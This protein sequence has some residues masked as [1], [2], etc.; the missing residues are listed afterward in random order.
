MSR[1]PQQTYPYLLQAVFAGASST[2]AYEAAKNRFAWFWDLAD[3]SYASEEK[4]T[5]DFDDRDV[6]FSQKHALAVFL[7]KLLSLRHLRG[8][9]KHEHV[10]LAVPDYIEKDATAKLLAEALKIAGLP[11][12]QEGGQGQESSSTTKDQDTGAGAGDGINSPKQQETSAASSE[13]VFECAY[14]SDCLATQW[15]HKYADR[16]LAAG[17]GK[18]QSVLVVDVGY[19]QSTAFALEVQVVEEEAAGAEAEGAEPQ[20]SSKKIHAEI[21]TKNSS[22]WKFVMIILSA[23]SL[24]CSVVL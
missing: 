4:S 10:V 3:S 23:R 17:V 11:L 15:I 21:L 14:H 20:A 12:F 22:F 2:D 13:K 1:N 9:E 5:V 8:V 18:P 19:S 6:D 16:I 24:S 7:K